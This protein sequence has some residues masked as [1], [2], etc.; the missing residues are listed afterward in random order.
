[1]TNND[2]ETPPDNAG[3]GFGLGI[4]IGALAGAGAFY[5][6][7]TKKGN[8][9]KEKLIDEYYQ[10]KEELENHP[11]F[12]AATEKMEQTAKAIEAKLQSQDAAQAL[13][14]AKSILAKL[15]SK[16]V[17]LATKSTEGDKKSDAK[18]KKS[19]PKSSM[20]VKRHFKKS[21]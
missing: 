20:S 4:V 6:F 3:G 12:K 16:I 11:E 1:M 10:A 13:E 8:L 9:L 14:E 2:H 15:N 7:G 21:K 19:T 18:T 17:N 5:L